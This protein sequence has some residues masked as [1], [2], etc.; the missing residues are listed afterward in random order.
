[1]ATALCLM[2][3][4]VRA[5]ATVFYVD[6]NN[7]VPVSPFTNWVSAATNIQDAID[8]SINGDL[9]MVTN[10][11]YKTGGRMGN[12]PADP[13]TTNRV[14]ISKS[15]TVQSV[16]GPSV[17]IIQGFHVGFN[18]QYVRCVFFFTN[19]AF[20]TGFTLTNGGGN[21]GGVL[22]GRPAG[23]LGQVLSNN[24]AVS[25]C[26]ITGSING[27]ANNCVLNNCVISGN[28]NAV[29][30]GG[31]VEHCILN[32]C[33]LTNNTTSYGQGGGADNSLL[34]NCLLIG[35]TESANANGWGGGGANR[36]TLNNCIITG[37][38]AAGNGGGADNSLLNN[39]I[40]TSNSASYGGGAY[41]CTLTNCT[42]IGNSATS[43]GGGVDDGGIKTNIYNCIVFYNAAPSE[44]NI[45]GYFNCNY[46]CTTPLP[47]NGL[48]NITNDPI[49]VNP[50]AGDFHLQSNSPC[51]NAGGNSWVRTTNDFDGN[52]RIVGGTVDI[53]AYEYQTPSS[54]LSYVWA[55]QYDLPTDGS[56]DFA[57]ADS[58][59]MNNWQEWI[60]G[61]NPTNAASVL[62][63]NPPTTNA[64]GLKVSWQSVNTRTYYLQRSTN[65]SVQPAFSFIKSNL[66]GQAGIT[67]FTDTSATNSSYF[68]YRV[69]VQ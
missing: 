64:P 27:G 18:E 8:A 38:F 26:V 67:S 37:N 29:D 44:P 50:A 53:G 62:M 69:G 47:T 65:L 35:N 33:T 52:P 15:V 6:V 1:M 20:L 7:A 19:N 16:N 40:I 9:I 17:T 31:G 45:G 59:G 10:G 30:W 51:I 32:N 28:T 25:N 56:A 21:G 63:I 55:Q 13:V 34:N 61:T 36:S 68:F 66:V 4:I 11:V 48:G 43:T 42:I 54:I 5:P 49:F 22:G 14:V 23:T 41:I 57:D 12:F 2:L 46:G 3:I 39:C 60:A 24:C 58:D